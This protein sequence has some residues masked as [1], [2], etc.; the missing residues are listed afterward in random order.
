MDGKGAESI[1]SQLK[2]F[3][4]AALFSQE[5]SRASEA[6]NKPFLN[7]THFE[8]TSRRITNVFTKRVDK[9]RWRPQ[10]RLVRS[11]SRVTTREEDS[12]NRPD[13]DAGGASWP[14]ARGRFRFC[15]AFK[16]ADGKDTKLSAE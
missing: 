7:S 11:E 9:L 12:T 8:R 10:A 6:V 14:L 5:R 1:E 16:A 3:S 2:T 15:D 4:A 13:L